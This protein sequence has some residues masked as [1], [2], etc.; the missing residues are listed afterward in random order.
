MP[1]ATAADVLKGLGRS[2]ATFD[3][4]YVQKGKGTKGMSEAEAK[5]LVAAYNKGTSGQKSAIRKFVDDSASAAGTKAAATKAKASKP[6]A[7]AKSAKK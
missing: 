5:K 7:K 6:K 2:K 3:V 1:A 4:A